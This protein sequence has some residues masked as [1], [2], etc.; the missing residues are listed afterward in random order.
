MIFVTKYLISFWNKGVNGSFP[1]FQHTERRR[2]EIQALK[3]Q[4]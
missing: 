1:I 3:M 2:I 4:K